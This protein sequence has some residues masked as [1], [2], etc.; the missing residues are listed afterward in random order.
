MS[1]P[2]AFGYN[3]YNFKLLAM[4]F[5]GE[6]NFFRAVLPKFDISA[7]FR[8]NICQASVRVTEREPVKGD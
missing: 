8:I 5:K 1:G 3:G 4:K 6:A 2:F 7:Q